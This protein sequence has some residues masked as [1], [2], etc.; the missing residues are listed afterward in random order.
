MRTLPPDILR[1]AV[2]FVQGYRIETCRFRR[3]LH[4]LDGNLR[5]DLPVYAKLLF[6]SIAIDRHNQGNRFSIRGQD[7]FLRLDGIPQDAPRTVPEIPHA[8]ETHDVSF[9]CLDQAT[10]RLQSKT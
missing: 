2:D 7:Y 1:D 8:G 9:L 10:I 3:V 6:Q 5:T 4:P